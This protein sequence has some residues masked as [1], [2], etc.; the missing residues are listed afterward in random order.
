MIKEVMQKLPNFFVK[1]IAV[2]FFILMGLNTLLVLTKTAIFPKDYQETLFYE[3][4]NAILNIIFLIIFS[5]VILILARYF[6]KI[7]SI[8]RLVLIVMIYSFIISILFAILRRDYV[9]FDPFNV[10]DQANNFIRGNYSGLEKGNNYLYIYSHQITTVFIFQII[11]SLF[12]RAT[13]ILYIMQSFSI[14]FIIFML[15][16]ISNILFEDEDTNYLVVILS[17]LC[18]PL[19]FYVAFV[20]GILPGMFLT[21]VAYYYFIKYTKQKEWYLLVVSAISINI[22]ILFIGN[23]MIHMIAIF[24]AAVIYFIRK[25]DKKILA[26][27][28]SCLFLMTTSKSIIYNYYEV[29]S[30]KEIAPGVPKITWIAMGMQEGDREA[31]WWNRFNY[32]IMPEE[33]FDAERITEISKDSIKQRL[34]VFRNNP[35]YAFDFYER[36]YENQFIEP[37]FQSLL[38]TAPQ[39]NFDNE[40]TLEK[41]KDFFIKQ[42][43]FNETHHVLM[44]IMKVFQVFV[45]SFS[46]VFAVNI[47][48]KK[49]EVLTIIPVAFVGGTLFHMIWEA[50]SRYVFPYFVFLIP[51]AAYGLIIFRNKIIEYRKTKEEKN[52]K[53]NM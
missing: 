46:F 49:E 24:T 5:I 29:T 22:A 27:I 3:N 31:G 9:Q 14:S 37:S 40:T 7:I 42:I 33:D 26:F 8:K 44:F 39:R 16:K 18:F 30:Q 20:Y 11:L 48:R 13:F 10:I 53:S 15:Y 32:D 50:K 28:L 36:K 41:V 52:E 45:Y 12:G 38:V 19:V 34:T 51:V 25:K 35:R 21:L 17:A 4:D 1:V 2:I 43:Y 6:K 47:F 23:N